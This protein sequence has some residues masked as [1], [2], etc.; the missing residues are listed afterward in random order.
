MVGRR[1]TSTSICCLFSSDWGALA[2]GMAPCRCRQLKAHPALPPS[3]FA[4]LLFF[5]R[6]VLSSFPRAVRPTWPPLRVLFPRLLC[7]CI[8]LSG[9]PP[10]SPPAL[11]FCD[12]PGSSGVFP[13][14]TVSRRDLNSRPSDVKS[15]TKPLDY[16]AKISVGLLPCAPD[17][18]L[19]HPSTTISGYH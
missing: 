1:S 15:D 10:R 16:R 11:G 5:C 17:S 2:P 18:G 14:T 12:L 19:L 3:P 6:R 8:A 13:T 4:S 7:S 9:A